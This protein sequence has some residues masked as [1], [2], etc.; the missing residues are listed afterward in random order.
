[1]I[2]IIMIMSNE[3]MRAPALQTAPPAASGRPPLR[4]SAYIYIYIHIYISISTY[5][6]IYLSIYLSLY[7]SIYLS[8]SLS[9][10]IYIYTY[11]KNT[12]SP[13]ASARPTPVGRV[14]PDVRTSGQINEYTYIYIYVYIYIY[15]H[16]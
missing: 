10:A 8:L 13:R 3:A 4:S 14:G 2:I 15:I 16:T 5:L 11:I 1:M 6:S 9:L 12:S 7:I